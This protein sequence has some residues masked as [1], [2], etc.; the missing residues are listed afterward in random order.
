VEDCDVEKSKYPVGN[1]F[2]LLLALAT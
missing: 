1:G 2:W